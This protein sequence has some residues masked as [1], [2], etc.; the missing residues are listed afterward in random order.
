MVDI[1]E[2]ILDSIR[3]SGSYH[4]SS[5]SVQKKLEVDEVDSL[6]AEGVLINATRALGYVNAKVSDSFA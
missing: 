6:I 4:Y 3:K 5:D 2:Q 1:R